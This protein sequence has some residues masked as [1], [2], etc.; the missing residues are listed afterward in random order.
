MSNRSNHIPASLRFAKRC[1][2]I[3]TVLLAVVAL[4]VGQLASIQ[5]LNGRATA[6]AATASRTLPVT[7]SAKRG[8]I[9]DAN[10]SVLAQSVER[11]TVIGNPEASQSFKPTTCTT[12]TQ[13]NCHEIDGKPVG[14][15]GAAAVAML[16]APVL[17]MDPMDLG[18]KL[19]GTGQ[20]A[21]L[22][23]DVT[24]QIKRSIEKLNLGGYI[25]FELSSERLYS[26]GTMI[27]ALLGGV[28]SEGKGVAGI[29]QLENSTLTG[30]NGYK[31]YQQGNGGEE[32]PGTV[33]ESKDAVDGSD[34][35]LTIDA[36][37]DWY[38]KKVLIEAKETYQAGWALA[39]VQDTQ[40]GQI[41]ALDDSDQ[42]DAGSSDAKLNVARS[43]ST[44]FEPGSI[45]KVIS[46]SGMLQTGSNTITDQ[47]TVP[48]QY[49]KNG[50]T[51]KDATTHGAEH[52]TL[53]G[54]LEQSSNV[55]MV[56]ASGKYTN[57]Q[58]YEFMT[59]FGVGQDSGLNLPGESS[60]VLAKPE[61]WDG[62]TQDTVLFGQGYTMNALQ[63]TNAI[64]TIANKGVRQQQT[65]VKSI[66]D[67]DGH[68]AAPKTSE[69][70]RVVDEQ[71]A[72]QVLDAMESAADHYSDFAG[73]SGYRVAAKSGTAEVL[74]AD[75]SLSS[76][77]S[78]W[79]GII[80]ADNPRFVITVVMKDPQG[81]FGGLTSGPVF[82]QIGEF[83]MQKYEVP[84]STERK[85]AIA[86]TW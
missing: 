33:T 6:N 53:A 72:A 81:S 42:I 38:V 83:L 3:G 85:N 47:Y 80:P 34:V 13:G 26:N 43:V 79:S 50:Q 48:D 84:V 16:L 9:L 44:T 12:N 39:V 57:A 62:R 49:T 31:V 60:G 14:A 11:Y 15:T 56:L 23:K 75:G 41:I 25:S 68:S 10:G 22:K 54:I 19:S 76:R 28:D 55:G 61:V 29:E 67:A 40:T 63:I 37:V 24:P 74:G 65:I 2:V 64:A 21:V 71:V 36:D 4:C 66:T 86:L 17:D 8:K 27:G 1:K 45:G 82:K 35:S 78:D 58:R 77:I 18:A 70:T 51:F 69:P 46:L 52:W 32:I 5:L 59:K 20:Y 73:V 30:T 7:I